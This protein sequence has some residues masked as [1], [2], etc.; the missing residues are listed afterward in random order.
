LAEQTELFVIEPGIRHAGV[1]E[2]GAA[3][4]PAR[5]WPLP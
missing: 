2:V 3:R 4:S 5:W 1:D